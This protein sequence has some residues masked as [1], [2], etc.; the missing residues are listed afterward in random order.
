MGWGPES[1]RG[2]ISLTF[3]N[4]GE[5]AELEFGLWPEAQALG[6]H[7]TAKQVLPQILKD[8]EQTKVPAT[9]FVE[10]W[11]G[12]MYPE[13][14][15]AMREQGHEVAL[16]GWRHEFW[17]D[18]TF[19]ARNEILSKGQKA[20]S[21]LDIR[22]TGFR[23]PGGDSTPDTAAQLSDAGF[24]YVSAAGVSAQ[25]EGDIVSLPFQW[26]YVDA[27]YF[28]PFMTAAREEMFGSPDIRPL[29]EW[30]AALDKVIALAKQTGGYYAVIFHP[31]LLG[32]E[33]ERFEPFRMFIEKLSADNDIWIAPCAEVAR[34]VHDN[35]Q[36]ISGSTQPT[37]ESHVN[38]LKELT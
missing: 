2:A 12:D 7:F 38:T 29:D 27:L 36:I 18:K 26:P 32:L 28:E 9:F 1:R 14:L 35:P 21:S 13:A 19:D 15:R 33:P 8:L 11:N 4:F 20:F 25:K 16:H 10:G 23:P 22:P 3:D 34:W 37:D 5:A 6:E 17:S 30:Q 31:Y 24:S